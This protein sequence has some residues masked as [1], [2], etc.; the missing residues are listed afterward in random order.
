MPGATPL[1]FQAID[2]TTTSQPAQVYVL[3]KNA[4]AESDDRGLVHAPGLRRPADNDEPNVELYD[5]DANSLLFTLE[6]W[7]AANGTATL[8][9]SSD[10]GTQVVAQFRRLIA[11]GRYSLFLRTPGGDGARLVP[12]D[13]AGTHNSFDAVQDGTANVVVA[14]PRRLPSGSQIVVVYHS[15]ALDHGAT[16]GIVGKDAHPQLLVRVP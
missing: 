5:A 1:T 6:K 4:P 16:P 7:R 3:D 13:G 11:F 10:G 14:V 9:P 15:D 8:S 2:P 12:L